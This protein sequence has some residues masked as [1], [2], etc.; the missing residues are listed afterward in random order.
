[1]IRSPD[2]VTNG[3]LAESIANMTDEKNGLLIFMI[4]PHLSI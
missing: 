1:M 3:S 2:E 4:P